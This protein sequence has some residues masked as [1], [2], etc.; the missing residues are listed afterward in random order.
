M[1]RSIFISAI[2]LAAPVSTASALSADQVEACQALSA[3]LAP[4]QAEII[5]MKD[6]RDAL[7]VV[8]ETQGEA[9]Q[10][11]EVHRLVSPSLAKKADAAQ[12]DYSAKK[13]ELT[14]IEHGIQ[15]A[16]SQY[17]RDVADYNKVCATK[18]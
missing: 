10:E 16:L 3:T 11:A 8:V 2:L 7:V 5:E 4:K 6:A 9:W 14:Q 13:R 18:K 15:A 12:S 1:I 17:N